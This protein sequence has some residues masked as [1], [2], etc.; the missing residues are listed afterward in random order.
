MGAGS[1]EIGVRIRSSRFSLPSTELPQPA[2]DGLGLVGE[3][4]AQRHVALPLGLV[5][6]AVFLAQV[7][8]GDDGV[9]KNL[10]IG[11]QKSISVF[12][13]GAIVDCY[14]D[15]VSWLTVLIFTTETQSHR[16]FEMN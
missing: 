11:K 3:H 4:I 14:H 8:D 16:V 6:D 13:F 9:H 2:G 10:E 12:A 1:W 5:L 15:G 7:F